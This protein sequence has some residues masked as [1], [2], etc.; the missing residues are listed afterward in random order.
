MA[1]RTDAAAHSSPYLC[2][3]LCF[4]SCVVR[5]F[6]FS[7]KRYSRLD[8]LNIGLWSGPLQGARRFV[9][10]ITFVFSFFGKSV[11]NCCK[12]VAMAAQAHSVYFLY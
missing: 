8:L 11:A 4:F 10:F 2:L 6:T 5:S 3:F 9:T 12:L 7:T 1:A